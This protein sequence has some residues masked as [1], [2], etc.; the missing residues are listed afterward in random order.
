M[1]SLVLIIA[2][3]IAYSVSGQK[4]LRY[5]GSYQNDQHEAATANYS[6]YQDAKT[7]KKVKHGSF[8]YIVKIKSPEKRLYRNITGEYIN[9][10]KNGLWNYSYTTKDYN[11]NN[12]GYFYTYNVVLEA[13]YNHGWPDGEW[14]YSAF[15]KRRKPIRSNGK[16][17]WE[18]YEIVQNVKIKLNYK[19]GILVDSLWI[20]NEQG[21]NVDVLMNEDGLLKGDFKISS[22]KGAMSYFFTD[23]FRREHNEDSSVYNMR[24]DYYLNNKSALEK[25][26][27]GIEASSLFDNKSCIISKTLN[28][29]VFNNSFFNYQYIDGDRIIKVIGNRKNVKVDYKGLY[30]R[31]LSIVISQEEQAKIQLVYRFYSNAKTKASKCT[32]VYKQS[33]N[34]VNLRRKMDQAKKIQQQLKAYLCQLKAYKKALSGREIELK[35]SLCN[36]DIKI[37]AANTRAQILNAI[38]NRAKALDEKTKKIKCN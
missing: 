19:H 20:R 32:Q 7:A 33:N 12:D 16:K 21:M 29:H 28:N 13:N 17:K 38:Y 24:Y 25:A 27:A 15:V 36:S 11:T 26:G 2:V 9:G 8:R 3:L 1:R 18:P 35:S 34:D 22:A 4:T 37:N 10:W 14:N 30:V 6:Y 23:G 31:E 5:E